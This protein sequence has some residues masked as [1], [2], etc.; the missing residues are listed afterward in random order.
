MQAAL[1]FDS[2]PGTI[3]TP[4]DTVS[5][6]V[7]EPC[8]PSH[9]NFS[10][11]LLP[12]GEIG[13]LAVGGHQLARGYL[14][15]PEQT[16]S[17]FIPS[18]YGRVY[19]TG[20]RARLTA[21]GKLECFG[22]LANGQ[23]KLRGQR[24]ELGEIEQAALST[25]GCH[26]AVAAIVDSN[27]V[28]FCAVDPDVTED[29]I[30]M[31]CQKWLPLF[32]I[33]GEVIMLA[34][35]PQLPSGKVDLQ[36]LKSSY[37]E[38]KLADLG[39]KNNLEEA[40]EDI[41]HAVSRTLGRKVSGRM[42]LASAGVDSLSAISLAS[43]LR[44]SGFVTTASELL[45]L[46][47]IS[48][49]CSSIRNRTVFR[50]D[51]LEPLEVSLMADLG[52]ILAHSPELSLEKHDV[53][54]VLP[55][56]SLQSAML[57]ETVRDPQLYSNE[58]E[59]QA[60]P[61][62]TPSEVAD[63]IRELAKRNEI[64]RSGFAQWRGGFVTILY[65]TFDTTDGLQTVRDFQHGLSFTKSQEFLRPLR[66]QICAETD[67]LGLRLLVQAHHAVY[68]G[69]SMD[70][71]LSDLSALLRRV[72]P[73]P[74]QQFREV[75]RYHARESKKA[76]DDLARKFW[77]E[78]L[79]SWSK[80][81]FP[82][83]TARL[84]L[85]SDIQTTRKTLKVPQNQVQE[86][87]S[88]AA[89][90][91]QVPFQASLGLLWSG[92]TGERD[93]VL[94]SVTSGR[95]I[96]V[97]RVEE[98]IG[99]CVAALPLRVNLD[100]M[101]SCADLLK[102][103]QASNRAIM[104]H[105]GL[106]LSEVK[107]ITELQPT[108][109]LYDVLFVYQQSLEATKDT[110]R[111]L[112]EVEHI[113]RLETKLLFEIQPGERSYAIQA[114]YHRSWF[115]PGLIE[116]LMQQFESTLLTVLEHPNSRIQPGL[117]STIDS[118]STYNEAKQSFPGIPDLATQFEAA[119]AKS[120][121][122]TALCFKSS[123]EMK[124]I[125]IVTFSYRELNESANQ[126]A[127][128]LGSSG[129]RVGEVLAII[130]HK[131]PIFYTSVLG[132][133]KAGCAYLPILP[134]TPEARVRGI[135][136]QARVR[137]CLVDK[138]SGL[139][140][141]DKVRFHPVEDQKL[142][143]HS[144]ENKG[145][146]ADPSRLAYVI[147]TSGTTGEPKGVAVTQ[148]NIVS[149]IAFLR[150]TYPAPKS[151]F[152]RL[153]QACS[154]A[155]DVSVFEIFFAWHAGM[156]LCA[157]ANDDMFDDLE[158]SIRQLEITH[159]SLTPTVASL[160][161]PANVPDV[162]FLVTAG[163]PMT[164]SVLDRWDDKL[165]QGY[166]PSE[167]TNICSV[168]RM[169]RGDNIEHL[170]W[171]LPNTSAFVMNPSSLEIVPMGWMGEFCFGGDQVA[172][173]YLNDARLTRE[174]FIDHPKFGRIYRSGDVG[175]MLPD[176]SLII[177]GRLD[178]QI[179]LR[180][181]RIEAGEIN[182]IITST[183]LAVAAVTISARRG[184]GAADQ[185]VSFYVPTGASSEFV[186]VDID[187]EAIRQL[188]AS[189]STR[190]PSYMVPSYVIPVSQI[191]VGSSGKI[192][193]RRLQACFEGLAQN[194]ME[195]A[196]STTK[197]LD[198]HTDW[199][200]GESVIAD[201]LAHSAGVA[202]A[203][204]GRWT[205][206]AALGVDS[207]TAIGLSRMLNSKIGVPIPISAV[208]QNPTVAQLAKYVEANGDRKKR[209]SQNSNAF[210]AA[211]AEEVG[212]SLRQNAIDV[213]D[214]YP[215]TPLQ[216][217]MLSQGSRGYFNKILLRLRIRAESMR[218]HWRVVSH[219]H[220]ILR[221]CFI[222]TRCAA[223]PIAQVV[224]RKWE[225]PWRSFEVS[226][227][228]LAGAMQEHLGCLPEPLDT[229]QPPVSCAFI[230]HKDETFFSL[231]CH[232]AMYD[233]VAMDNLW[234]EIEALANGCTLP[235]AVAYKP[236]IQKAISLPDDTDAFW[237][238]HF[239]DF[240]PSI[241]FPRLA[242]A[243]TNQCKHS[244]SLGVTLHDVQK[245]L[246]SLGVSM[247]SACQAAWATLISI[248]CGR[249]DVAFGNVVNGRT[250]DLEGLDRLVAPCFN[251]VPLRADLSRGSRNVDVV[252][253]FQD[254]N[255]RMLRYQF[256][257]LRHVRKVAN[258][259]SRTLFDT[260]LLLQRPSKDMDESVW[261]LE[262][263][264]GDMDVPLVCEIIPQPN[265]DSIIVSVHYDIE[266]V[267][268]DAAT[269][270]ADTF[271][272]LF[273]HLIH[274]PFA[275]PHSRSSIPGTLQLGIASLVPRRV[276][277]NGGDRQHLE[278]ETWSDSENMIR[279]I[280]SELS[281]VPE[282]RISRQTGIFR[283][284][285]DSINAVQVASMLKRK[286]Y[287]VSA[288]DVVQYSSCARLAPRLLCSRSD[289]PTQVPPTE[290]LKRYAVH[291]STQFSGAVP[292]DLGQQV[293][294]ILPTTSMQ[295]AMLAAFDQSE[296][297]NYLNMLT[298]RLNYDTHIDD[299]LRAWEVLH[300]QHPMLRTGFA[301][302]H[303]KESPFA[304]V[305]FAEASTQP[306]VEYIIPDSS[307]MFDLQ[308]WQDESRRL[309]L[310]CPRLPPWKV[311]L[312][313]YG[314]EVLMNL[315]IHHALY[316]AYSLGEILSSLSRFIRDG[317]EPC[318][319][320]IEPALAEVL[321]RERDGK[322]E[323]RGFWERHADKAVVNKF[324]V[325]TP[326]RE[327]DAGLASCEA[328][329]SMT[330]KTLSQA[331]SNCEISIQTA[332]QS[333]WARVLASYLGES[334]VVFGVTMSGRNTE[335]TQDAPFP[336]ITTVPVVARN[337]TSNR[338][339]MREMMAFNVELQRHQFSPLNQI[340]KWLGHP[341]TPVF[342][343]LVVYQRRES[344]QE[345][346]RSF[347]L[348]KDEPMVEYAVSVEVEATAEHIRLRITHAKDVLP[349]EQASL[350]LRQFDATLQHLV[351]DL[352]D[353]EHGL[354]QKR[355]D[356]F[357]V[358]PAASP[359]LPAPVQLLHEFVERRAV[360]DPEST[361]LEFVSSFDGDP[362]VRR[363][364]YKEFDLMGD[365]AANLL[366][367]TTN[368]G[369][370]VAI[371]FDKCPEAYISI[372]GIL[373]AG[374]S[375]VAL[376][377][378][379][380]TAR[381]D[382]ILRD[383]QAK[384][385][386]TDVQ[387]TLDFDAPAGIVRID[388]ESLQRSPDRRPCSKER[389]LK[390]C[391][392]C[393]CLYTSGTTGTPKGCEISHENAVQ[394]MM[395]FQE[396]FRGHWE[397]ESRWLQFAALHFDVSVLEQ[398][399][400]WSVGIAVVAAPRDLVLDDLAGAIN[401]LGI[402]HI[403]LTP[404]LA[405]LTHPDEMP[406]LCRG[407]FITGG[408]QL[409]QEILDSW[410]PK[411]VI[412]N[413][414]GPTEATIGVTMYPRVPVNGRPSNIGK[415]F[416]NVGSYVFHPGTEMPVL[417]GGVGELCVSGKL[418][419]K[420]YLNRRELTKERFPT[421][422]RFGERVYR[423]G[424]LVRILH[425]GCFEFLG[426][427]D[428]QIKLRGQRL[429]IGEI[430][431]AIRTGVPEL[432]NVA[433]ILV[434]REASGK[435]A[436]VSF[437]VE[438]QNNGAYDLCVLPDTGGL[439]AKAR[440]ACLE[441]LPSYMIPSYYLRLSRVPLSS[442]NKVES[443][444]LEA[445]FAKLS[446]EQLMKLSAAAAPSQDSGLDRTV[447]EK[448]IRLV[449]DFSTVPADAISSSTSIF[450]IGVDSI[451]AL[452]L[453]TLLRRHGFPA[454]SPALLLRH[455]IVA[456]LARALSSN[457]VGGPQAN[458]VREARQ[459]IQACHHRH[460][461]LVCRELG[462][463]PDEIEY[464]APCSPLQQGIIF[465]AIG[466]EGSGAYF[467]SFELRLGN[468]VSLEKV[469][470]AW[471]SLVDS[472]AILR[473]MFL[474][475]PDGYVQIALKRIKTP[476]REIMVRFRD[477]MD[478]VMGSE[479]R[480]WIN[481]NKPHLVRP[482]E[483]VHVQ[484]P[485]LQRVFIHIFHA[486]Y[487]GNSLELMSRYASAIYHDE[488]PASAPLFIDAL[489]HGPLQRYD[490]CRQFWIEH[491]RGWAPSPLPTLPAHT[492]EKRTVARTSSVSLSRLEELRS[493][494]NV[495]LQSVVLALWTAVLQRHLGGKMSIGIIV[496]GRSMNLPDVERTI[497]P[498]FNTVPLFIRASRGRTW[499]SLIREIHTFSTSTLP[500]QHVPLKS[501]QK[502]CSGGWSIFDNLFAFQIEQPNPTCEDS[503]WT[504]EDCPSHADYPLAFEA[505]CTLGG[506]LR[507]SLV[508]QSLFFDAAM[509]GRLIDQFEHE[510]GAAQADGL[511]SP[512]LGDEDDGESG[513]ESGQDGQGT[514]TKAT[515]FEWT[516]K[517]V[518]IREEVAILAGVPA[519]EVTA[520]TTLLQLGLD[521]ID[522]MKLSARLKR[523]AINLSASLILRCQSIMLMVEQLELDGCD[524][525]PI[526][527]HLAS[528]QEVRPKLYAQ[529]EK[530]GLDLGTVDSVLPSTALQEAMVVGMVQSGFHWYFNHD[531][532][533]VAEG[534]DTGR[535]C[536][537]WEDVVESSPILRTGFVEVDDADLDMAYCQVTF[538]NPKLH[539]KFVRLP[540]L[541]E[542]SQVTSDATHLAREGQ[543]LKNLVQLALVH[544]GHKRFVVLSMAH[545]L[546][547]GW[548]LGLMYRDLEVAYNGHVEAR[549]SA[550]S[551]ISCLLATRTSDAHEFWQN[552]LAGVQPSFLARKDKPAEATSGRPLRR[553][554]VSKKPL[555]EVK[556][557]CRKHSVSLQTLC[558]ASWAMVV[559]ARV[560]ALDVVF[561]VVLSGRDGEGADDLMFPTM[562][563]VALR[564]ILH[565]T[566][567]GLL[568]YL[569][570]SMVDVR[571][572]QAFPLR[573]A[574]SAAKLRSSSSFDSL[575]LFQ[576][577][578][579]GEGPVSQLLR[580]IGGES[581]V[582]Y[583]VCIEVEPLG[584]QL[585]WRIACHAQLFSTE[586]T[587][588]LVEEADRVL[589]YILE[590]ENEDVLSFHGEDVSICGMPAVGIKGSSSTDSGSE[591]MTTSPQIKGDGWGKT[592][593]VIRDVLV[594]VSQVP[595]EAMTPQSSLY[596]LGLDSISAIKV[597]ILLRK[598][599]LYL[600]PRELVQAPSIR[601]LASA[602]GLEKESEELAS[603]GWAPPSDIDTLR[604]LRECDIRQESVEMIL[605]ATS[606]QVYMLTAWQN[607]FG[608]VFFPEFCYRVKGAAEVSRVHEA[609]TSLVDEISILRTRF[610]ATGSGDLPWLQVVIRKGEMLSCRVSQP[611][612]C[613]SVQ[614]DELEPGL[615]LRLRI[616]H[617]LYDGFSLP[618]V[619]SRLGELM[620]G[621]MVGEEQGL[622]PWARHCIAPGLSDAKQRRRTFWT[623]YLGEGAVSP[624]SAARPTEST[625]RVSYFDASAVKD[626]APLRATASQNGI[627]L[628][629]LFLA[630]LATCLGRRDVH[631]G[632]EAIVLGTYL[633]NR[634]ADEEYLTLAVNPTLNLAPVMVRLRRD[635][636]L[637][638]L[639]RSIQDDIHRISSDGRAEV[640][641][642]EIVAWTGVTVDYFVNFL[643]SV[644]DERA[645]ADS[646]RQAEVTL[647]PA[648]ASGDGS[649]TSEE[650]SCS[651]LL[652]QPW[653]QRNAVRDAYPVSERRAPIS[654]PH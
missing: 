93:M 138:S 643:A 259:P 225:V 512:W 117:A 559:A 75:L 84:S 250:V 402:T 500:F 178:D 458:P 44:L 194:Y 647:T 229:G 137:H 6:F 429:E 410:G 3:G 170:G 158:N 35:F 353:D 168:K 232:H 159:L 132:I 262:E 519:E 76:A 179:K 379:A 301:S 561:G 435:D 592:E 17:A 60:A 271:K 197:I 472:H 521:S 614:R 272:C 265:V 575:F 339:L 322:S 424:D 359:V 67:D 541:S 524:S 545:A 79:L 268:G 144:K 310:Q 432:H 161:D 421:L 119:T 14:N 447:L 378:H 437:L 186:P 48:E 529:I 233:G 224:L 415:Q 348:V 573:R 475:T 221:T 235:P 77:S 201:V 292:S 210:V 264:S 261:T 358:T 182:S 489:T 40:D 55:C 103:I 181:Q 45:K 11:R 401:R 185:L 603:L 285:L 346:E 86:A 537:A 192:D 495:T 198:N 26:G 164:K 362:A 361:A 398:Y 253:H 516:D 578:T 241:L 610:V 316:D 413:A 33:P 176:G 300:R 648:P 395:A 408:E 71:I 220:A 263:D 162:E 525:P 493:Q 237:V 624:S 257:S 487:D 347:K 246:R 479:R 480:S 254:L 270:L 180:G 391:D 634:T 287:E 505:T 23:V 223:H 95:T 267:S 444:E 582:E 349:Q 10:F 303:H 491:M 485:G 556:L 155:F 588:A 459:V 42:T 345:T 205:P 338:E 2:T 163:E 249:P 387:I 248:A 222:T 520:A 644:P 244:T 383:S 530:A 297:Q 513:E 207:I 593:N 50:P 388:C 607:S 183:H 213:E 441:R 211:F 61:G 488:K 172:M 62:L 251:T 342:D 328:V 368:V 184:K 151:A 571:K 375:F 296:G 377:P 141:V 331:A 165:W 333:A 367:E 552:Y 126:I 602:A 412:Y 308:K 28:V 426:R 612:I 536:K 260:L 498:L 337:V 131:S 650:A 57:A 499:A 188:F 275:S 616:H 90:S 548:S 283:L 351:C 56:S 542:V 563:T 604:L 39:D 231:I 279:Q 425:D 589:Q 112:T 329:S 240:Q 278:N 403:D 451:T 269:A 539:I 219:R 626:I 531:I 455:P 420:G 152:P 549:P 326:L 363:W 456:D 171:T 409:R 484:G 5:C 302:V 574:H 82:R 226:E 471:I 29:A 24:V 565:G 509:L 59:L 357:A 51:G 324:P 199:T 470:M 350:L 111:L 173:G 399:W 290:V 31:H 304:M 63:A 369:D 431:H 154:Q 628:Q 609:W 99:P 652:E 195:A 579:E 417:R 508:A 7:I 236:F 585:T 113:D 115:P 83:L 46:K 483:L 98:I 73:P 497:G 136:K 266:L 189:L 196:A 468:E 568:Q 330:F 34:A 630:G 356:L 382:F 124:N 218:S 515:V 608:S 599:G 543:G 639:A 464:I 143:S 247:L 190:L 366:R 494:Q 81:P 476:W 448:V 78:H 467:N 567:S 414:Y 343:T 187:Q 394:A 611:L 376:D 570:E 344:V 586:E 380:P 596:E 523:K 142:V 560:G 496:A 104:E 32:M 140:S 465:K 428:D 462:L 627:S 557:F 640:G 206:F 606:M 506:E 390:P 313:N 149:N 581:T 327:E 469:R 587:E 463:G 572:F 594:Q 309:F 314:D 623:A 306:P 193:R 200:H 460:L 109:T 41:V 150:S 454:A 323:A 118:Q 580:S 238:E 100:S 622:A 175:R 128:Y 386:V 280:L 325:L 102:S 66:F 108:E 645:D 526:G 600:K 636:D 202:K 649:V 558:A 89:L 307:R 452:Q 400:S 633:A 130:M 105:C 15:R 332:L 69:W 146:P 653:L 281:G 242:G 631:G 638:A 273:S 566:V 54:D 449:S 298:Y 555:S 74:R 365:R 445:L 21:E 58:M 295:A 404:S 397:P 208:L 91:T 289:A 597:S 125:G 446:N 36:A 492:E 546:Y 52:Q 384:C 370:V 277:M 288:S 474:N 294:A 122:A 547:D 466:D 299:V 139:A 538:R 68:D 433:T 245:A 276:E 20:D 4:L 364:S 533:E 107:K 215:C 114:T 121:N 1:P 507:V 629:S 613:L 169:R 96:P 360:T 97:D 553:E 53:E 92:I 615:L 532:L 228:I 209:N 243:D 601:E 442:N 321:V 8:G 477:E 65:K 385:L 174:K 87:A 129:V 625:E 217:G 94:G 544:V 482:F 651:A 453:S 569:E 110:V 501:I 166:G 406:S 393:Y 389:R 504:I 355:P 583:P 621:A 38:R 293:E 25:P 315:I 518:L 147:Y 503:P 620:N 481:E 490:H 160:V 334:S 584:G 372:L 422:A 252:R 13:E 135:L 22:R 590:H 527:L 550:D 486:L 116:C 440:A 47:T 335:I 598:R 619:I 439:G 416:H 646:D 392:T 457:A 88:Q 511:V 43:A 64:L 12:R 157:A 320:S 407:V 551:F 284:G 239:R 510:L 191:P 374:C 618:A 133:A 72:S 123:S 438:Q 167:T 311:I 317:I 312:V 145:V 423:T 427:A 258:C 418:V 156:C 177:I 101:V 256:T 230:R 434:R 517:A 564:C 85:P 352:D 540:G 214:I 443:K 318:F 405:R 216:E 562:N 305:R 274:F 354:Y 591:T 514:E 632:R 554:S 419:G 461:A 371:H 204:I 473:S 70:V 9:G 595:A 534:V 577:P 27:L 80:T 654:R 502:W 396:L 286:G 18:P 535:L 605:P 30:V 528:L 336:C 373:K 127:H 282:N 478:D 120:P 411:A 642:W 227:P 319:P 637:V 37:G 255:A 436:L 153:L 106:A 340:Q 19:R 203:D 381:K 16:A 450:D 234:R 617:A 430:N 49:L 641:L 291:V 522:T 212:A 148:K 635:G 134:T 576:K 341:A